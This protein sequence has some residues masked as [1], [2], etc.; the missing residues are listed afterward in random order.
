MITEIVCPEFYVDTWAAEGRKRTD[1]AGSEF[2][3]AADDG[4]CRLIKSERDE[5][6]GVWLVCRCSMKFKPA[7]G[8]QVELR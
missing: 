8:K 6:G 5:F 7:D 3:N 1:V 2:H 4:V